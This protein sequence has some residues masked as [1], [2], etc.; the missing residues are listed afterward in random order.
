MK[1]G[2]AT[3]QKLQRAQDRRRPPIQWLQGV[4]VEVLQ[5]AGLKESDVILEVN[6]KGVENLDQFQRSIAETQP[7][8][9]VNLTVWREGAK[10]TIGRLD[11]SPGK[12][13]AAPRVAA[14]SSRTLGHEGVT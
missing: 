11:P 6:G 12:A 8:T 10:Q 3:G 4:A 14:S 5:E 9:K 7:G 1:Y 13:T 2:P